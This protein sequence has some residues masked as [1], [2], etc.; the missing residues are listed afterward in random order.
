MPVSSSSP[1]VGVVAQLA[2][3]AEANKFVGG[4][5]WGALAA[6]PDP[7]KPRGVRYQIATIVA[8][9]ACAVLA[10]ARSFTAIGEWVGNAS[11]QVLPAMP[12]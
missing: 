2:S 7:R 11:E 5:V 3:A 1:V 9:G 4:S 6:V 8:W 10:G 12:S